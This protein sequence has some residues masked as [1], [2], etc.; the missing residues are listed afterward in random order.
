MSFDLFFST[1]TRKYG[2]VLGLSYLLFFSIF[3]TINNPIATYL[4]ILLLIPSLTF[5]G[6]Y[7]YPFFINRKNIKHKILLTVATILLI[8]I[9]SILIIG[10]LFFIGLLIWGAKSALKPENELPTEV[11]ELI[12]L[13]ALKMN[14]EESTLTKENKKFVKLYKKAEDLAEKQKK[15]KEGLKYVN[16]ALKINPTHLSAQNLKIGILMEL[17][18]VKEAEE[19]VMEDFHNRTKE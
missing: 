17:G 19:F 12:L 8:L 14:E 2:T 1:Y 13:Q 5:L 6:Y 16:A 11:K 15:F 10:L 9:T 18:R 3:F 7:F 4:I